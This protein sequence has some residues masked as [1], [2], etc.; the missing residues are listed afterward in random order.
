MTDSPQAQK[1][2]VTSLV[3][4]D[5][6]DPSTQVE[7]TTARTGSVAETLLG[8]FWPQVTLT[9]PL[10]VRLDCPSS[11]WDDTLQLLTTRTVTPNWAVAE[12][13]STALDCKTKIP[14]ASNAV[15]TNRHADRGSLENRCGVNEVVTKLMAKNP[16]NLGCRFHHLLRDAHGDHLGA[17]VHRI[18]LSLR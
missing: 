10:L 9:G 15:C 8:A 1:F 11:D 4:A 13:A 2:S 3:P 18:N 6:S 14:A 7:L 17:S 5:S 16:S 12:P